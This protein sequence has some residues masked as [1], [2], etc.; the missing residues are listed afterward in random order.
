MPTH[1]DKKK[2]DEEMLVVHK[3]GPK[4]DPKKVGGPAPAVMPRAASLDKQELALIKKQISM[5][6]DPGVRRDLVGQIQAKFGN[7]QAMEVV[8]EM[9]IKTPDDDMKSKQPGAGGKGP[10]KA[11]T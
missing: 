6:K 1:D 11:K 2:H 4:A 8:R 10:T 3:A 9:R 5:T 7:D